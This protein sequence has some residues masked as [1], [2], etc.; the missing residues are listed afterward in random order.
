MSALTL[1]IAVYRRADFL[2]RV[3]IS[4]AGQTFTDYEVV[5]ADDGS[6]PEM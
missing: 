6:G 3:L 2:E 5:I 1:V 4:L